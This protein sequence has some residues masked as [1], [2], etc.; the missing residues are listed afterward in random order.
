MCSDEAGN[1]GNFLK[2]LSFIALF[3]S[4]V[5]NI[6][7]IKRIFSMIVMHKLLQPKQQ[8]KKIVN[9][10]LDLKLDMII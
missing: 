2:G 1:L 3:I 8:N 5:W 6:K 9:K 10:I 4:V 7:D